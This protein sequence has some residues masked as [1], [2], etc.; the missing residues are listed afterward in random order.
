MW[1]KVN[2]T[3]G[4]MK[5]NFFLVKEDRK[6]CVVVGSRLGQNGA[7]RGNMGMG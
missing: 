5:N 1:A 4:E 6:N 2:V 3:T 7:L